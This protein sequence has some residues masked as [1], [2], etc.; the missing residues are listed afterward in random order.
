MGGPAPPTPRAAAGAG[1]TGK[2]SGAWRERMAHQ[3]G[4][5]SS[6][7]AAEGR[8]GG[9]REGQVSWVVTKKKTLHRGGPGFGA[10]SVNFR[11]GPALSG[12]SIC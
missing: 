8:G 7:G 9:R 12:R 6:R 10:I 2:D 11:R 3:E 4:K 1:A 5:V